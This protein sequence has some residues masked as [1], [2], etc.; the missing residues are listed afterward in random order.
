VRCLGATLDERAAVEAS[1]DRTS[2]V[3]F[4][5]MGVGLVGMALLGLFD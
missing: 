5:V 4:V 1:Q 3:V 2:G